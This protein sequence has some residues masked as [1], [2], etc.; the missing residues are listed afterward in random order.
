MFSLKDEMEHRADNASEA[1]SDDDRNK[2]GGVNQQAGASE[3]QGG[4]QSGKDSDSK[5]KIAMP[6]NPMASST[7]Q[8]SETNKRHR[9]GQSRD[10]PKVSDYVKYARS[11]LKSAG[12]HHQ[13]Q[14]M[15]QIGS[16]DTEQYGVHNGTQRYDGALNP[17]VNRKTPIPN[18]RRLE[19]SKPDAPKKGVNKT[20]TKDEP[21][22]RPKAMGKRITPNRLEQDP[23][24][25]EVSAK[26][27]NADRTN[28]HIPK[29]KQNVIILQ[30][31]RERSPDTRRMNQ[32]EGRS[33]DIQGPEEA[34][35][36]LPESETGKSG[37]IFEKTSSEN[38]LEKKLSPFEIA[39]KFNP[40]FYKL[41]EDGEEVPM[42]IMD[43]LVYDEND[44][45]ISSSHEA[46][47]AIEELNVKR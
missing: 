32:T 41:G 8:E 23:V 12:S 18:T 25:D 27:R 15:L 6:Q 29:P 26:A 13:L 33:A 17:A 24:L 42:L 4:A 11:T 35:V 5:S 40:T 28:F 20:A 39:K 46:P 21:Y 36:D 10:L 3:D 16:G 43:G 2:P 31:Q 7:R 14:Q 1:D 30:S 34:P 44:A 47:N 38:Q 22:D 37:C 19:A 9:R 45:R